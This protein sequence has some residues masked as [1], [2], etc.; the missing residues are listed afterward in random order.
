[1]SHSSSSLQ[2]IDL[3]H[4][5]KSSPFLFRNSPKFQSFQRSVSDFELY[6]ES[7]EAITRTVIETKES[8]TQTECKDLQNETQIPSQTIVCKLQECKPMSANEV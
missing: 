3:N 6:L 5:N 1:L 4:I 2:S 8:E 7:T